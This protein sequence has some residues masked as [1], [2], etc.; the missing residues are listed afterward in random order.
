MTS[1]SASRRSLCVPRARRRRKRSQSVR[2]PA[3]DLVDVH[4]AGLG[5]RRL[6]GVGQVVLVGLGVL[7]QPVPNEVDVLADAGGV[8]PAHGFG[9]LVAGC[10]VLRPE[11]EVGDDL[12]AQRLVLGQGPAVRTDCDRAEQGEHGARAMRVKPVGQV[13]VEGR[14]L[15]LD[16]SQHAL[17]HLRR[18][19][20][21]VLRDHRRGR[22]VLLVRACQ[23][24]GHRLVEVLLG[25]AA[26]QGQ[27]APQRAGLVDQRLPPL[28]G[29]LVDGD[30]DVVEDLAVG[31]EQRTAMR[32]LAGQ[33]DRRQVEP[34][35]T[36]EH[37]S[38]T[39]HLDDGCHR[40]PVAGR[41]TS[42][43]RPGPAR[44]ERSQ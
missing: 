39:G 2:R 4:A 1:S 17:R 24:A 29:L 9:Q 44:P 37:A 34:L 18:D 15:G 20:V 22:H 8:V 13:G 42:G 6:V 38:G 33:S 32:L 5:R 14:V 36:E 26:R 30:R 41:T 40:L 11:R 7:A 43:H 35:V 10:A 27:L 12:G 31:V 3:G 19:R 21:E 28:G 25:S 23:Q 16:L